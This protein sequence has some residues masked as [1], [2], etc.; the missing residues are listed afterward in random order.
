MG[1]APA[2][3]PRVSQPILHPFQVRSI[4]ISLIFTRQNPE[5]HSYLVSR[6]SVRINELI[7]FAP[8]YPLCG[9]L[10]ASSYSWFSLI[11]ALGDILAASLHHRL[12]CAMEKELKSSISLI[13]TVGKKKY[14]VHSKIKHKCLL[15]LFVVLSYVWNCF[16]YINQVD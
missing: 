5:L 12:P 1:A 6:D 13:N 11:L 16:I 7:R 15:R 2:L 8:H 4:P 9:F 10:T 14:H 3:W